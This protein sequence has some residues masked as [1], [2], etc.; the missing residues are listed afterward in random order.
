MLKFFIFCDPCCCRRL[1]LLH[2]IRNLLPEH[3]GILRQPGPLETPYL[4]EDFE[5]VGGGDEPNTLCL[6]QGRH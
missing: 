4:T 5:M 2:Y 1:D 6:G 3:G